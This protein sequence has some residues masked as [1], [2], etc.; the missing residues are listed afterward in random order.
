[1]HVLLSTTNLASSSQV[2]LESP[3]RL[4]WYGPSLSRDDTL[5]AFGRVVRTQNELL[6]FICARPKGGRSVDTMRKASLLARR[7]F[8]LEVYKRC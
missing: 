4:Y 5:R 8:C 6:P 3:A 2:L 7:P 1:M